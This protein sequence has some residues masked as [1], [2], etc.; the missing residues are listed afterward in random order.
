MLAGIPSPVLCHN[1]H[2]DGGVQD[3][4]K[5]SGGWTETGGKI[6]NS[7]NGQEHVGEDAGCK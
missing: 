3:E 2:Q 6:G 1:C 4:S 5:D 7:S